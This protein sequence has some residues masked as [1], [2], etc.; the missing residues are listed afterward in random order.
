MSRALKLT[1]LVHS[2]VSLLFGLLMFVSPALWGQIAGYTQVDPYVTRVLGATLLSLA[3]ASWLGYRAQTWEAV[4]IP[5]EMELAFTVMGALAMLYSV[6][7]EAA[8]VFI[9][10]PLALFVIF[11][12]LW[13]YFL[14]QPH[15]ESTPTLHGS[16][17]A[18]LAR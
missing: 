1:F 5:V 14:A 4:R 7:F 9:W 6:L 3:L 10:V 17:P 13:G 2:L 18:P 15:A 16:G 8:P 12:V 11:A